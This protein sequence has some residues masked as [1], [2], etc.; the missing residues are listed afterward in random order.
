MIDAVKREVIANSLSLV[1]EEMGVAVV[2]SSFSTLIQESVEASA[3]VLDAKGRLLSVGRETLPTH[4]ASLR[5]GLRS[6]IEDFP[7]TTMESGDVYAMNDPFRGGVHSNDILVFRPVFVAGGPQYFTATLVHVADLGGAAAGGLP[8]KVTDTFGEGLVL[9]PVPL[10]MRGEENSAVM[11]IIAH[12]S[13]TPANTIGDVRAL[14]AGANVGAIRLEE[15]LDRFGPKT[16]DVAIEALLDQSEALMMEALRRIPSGRYA[17]EFCIDDDGSG[18]GRDYVV[19]ATV[20]V[21]DGHVVVDFAG[22]SEQAT[23]VINS[24]YSQSIAAAMFGIRGCVGLGLRLDE[25]TYRCIEV[26]LPPGSLVNPASPAACNGRMVTCTAAIEAIFSALAKADRSLAMAASGILHIYTMSGID[27]PAGHW[28]YLGVSIG[29][30][31]AS[32]G[33]DGPDASSTAMWGGGGRGF[34][35]IEPIEARYPVLFE[36]ARLLPDSGGPGRWRGG[37][38]TETRV[39]VL[40]PAQVTVRADRVRRPPPGLSGGQPGRAGG[41]LLW[42]NGR[43]IKRL[44]AKAMNVPLAAG[45]V[46]VMRTSGGGGVGDPRDRSRGCVVSDVMRGTVSLRGATSDYS[47]S[48]SRTERREALG[49]VDSLSD[50]VGSDDLGTPPDG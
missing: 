2:R 22:T 17:D 5:C 45:D 9:P 40:E 27:E 23:G 49:P 38:G 32:F 10:Y 28:G 14:V 36:S 29:G 11:R 7:L 1:A 42:R 41:Y 25:G 26:R 13:R 16:V 33:A 19:R 48:I 4:S 6:V 31:G 43:G 18:D 47:V 50:A 30:S 24:A 15:L 12:N 37:V 46:F 8:A 44:P 34:N 21:S 20:D 3:S 39:R 35:D